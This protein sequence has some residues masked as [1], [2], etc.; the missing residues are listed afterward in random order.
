[1]AKKPSTTTK[2]YNSLKDLFLEL[3]DSIRPPDRMSVSEAAENVR[4]VYQ[5]GSFIGWWDNT[6]TPYMVEPM[7]TLASR[8]ISQMAFVGPAQSGKTDA[9]IIN[10]IA[11]TVCVDPMD[12]MLFC[13]TQTAARD[14]SI[15]RVDRLHRYSTKVG[16]AQITRSDAD[17][18]FDKHY[19]AGNI[20]T[21]TYPS[22]T[23]LAGRPVPRIFMTDYD[24]MP[25]DIGGD[26]SGFDLA[27]KRTTT[28]GSFAMCVAESSPSRPVMDPKWIASSPHEAPP[29]TGILGLYNRGD[30]RRWQWPCLHCWEW[31]EGTFEL[32]RWD[33]KE[34]NL[35]SART[36]RMACPHCGSEIMPDDRKEM[37][38][39]GI[40]VPDG[41][42]VDSSGR[43]RGRAPTTKFRSYWLRGT[44]AAFV[45]WMDLVNI[46]LDACDEFERTGSEEA[47]KK[48]RNNDMG[49][50]YTPK[51][52]ESIRTPEGLMARVVH[53]ERG[54]V[55]EDVRV[56][57]ATV[58]VQ[59]Y[60]FVVQ[61]TGLRP[62]YPVDLVPID[63][64]TL[65]KSRATDQDGDP[66]PVSP[67]SRQEDWDLIKEKVMD[68]QYPL[69]DGSGRT[70]GIFFTGCDSGGRAGVTDR[71]YQFYRKLH[72]EGNAARFR[73]IKGASN[74][75][76][77]RTRTSYPDNS[78]KSNASIHAARG[79]IPLLMINTNALKDALSNRLDSV[80][81]GAGMVHLGSWL[82]RA[83]FAEMC[84]EI[85]TAK[86]WENPKQLR[87]EAFDL[88]NYAQALAIDPNILGIEAVN[89]DG[90]LPPWLEEWDKN[91][92][93]SIPMEADGGDT[94]MQR[95]IPE[96][97][98]FSKYAEQIA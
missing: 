96:K 94:V 69:G 38:Q 1:M 84:A 72:R 70:M 49:E 27:Y 98:D 48:F 32:L 81:P 77:P 55:P 46:Y 21:L 95:P 7:D 33:K 88:T 86:G 17:N 54:V 76:H 18:I 80:A 24:R 10:G 22:V 31:F 90:N 6:V 2:K 93:V 19:K 97:I 45:S 92:M 15:R 11:Y 9:I 35:A 64:F 39:W 61:V 63:Y 13:P 28:F 8:Q 4:Y 41:M 89:W 43:L 73:L 36:V 25:D 30:K 71:A 62:G 12:A 34:S 47:L 14:F 20:L 87:N 5:P 58:D 59:K 42:H 51:A 68:L 82:P 78:G 37:Q 44:A 50:P 91:V 56:L 85:R 75:N 66:L 53:G 57:V 60:Q 29:C 26:G 74:P 67:S 52:M 65:R 23:E 79:D 40:W 83:W 16:A 3:I